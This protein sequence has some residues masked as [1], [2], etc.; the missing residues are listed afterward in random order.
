MKM[1]GRRKCNGTFGIKVRDL[2]AF[3]K[4]DL[5]ASRKAESIFLSDGNAISKTLS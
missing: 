2:R 5:S 1:M 4:V 3:T